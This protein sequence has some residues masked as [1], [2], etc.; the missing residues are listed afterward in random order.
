MNRSGTESARPAARLLLV[1]AAAVL[2]AVPATGTASARPRHD[3]VVQTPVGTWSLKVSF[4]GQTF[5]ST[6]QFT[7]NGR[8]FLVKG[9]AGTWSRTG[10]DRFT[11]RIAEPI[12]DSQGHYLGR[13]DVSQRAV[14]T[15]DTFT[16]TG[17]S[18]QYD[19]DDRLGRV[20][21]AEDRGARL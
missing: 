8:A 11:F 20:V 4:G 15:G 10:D 14:Q 16:S 12:W 2:A 18:R 6:V 21:H 13:V 17:E 9:G 5:D 1:A 3:H 7:R 19:A